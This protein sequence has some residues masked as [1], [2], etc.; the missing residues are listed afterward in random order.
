M[1]IT[2]LK[3]GS[4]LLIILAALI[5]GLIPI[6]MK[7]SQSN[8]KWLVLGNAMAGGIFLGAGL[9]H[10][11]PESAEHFEAFGTHFPFAFVLA[12]IGF[13]LILLLEKVFLAGEHDVGASSAKQNHFSPFL[14]TLILS[15]H[16]IMYCL[17]R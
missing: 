14:L 11:L 9:L 8:E 17:E 4:I 2:F 1:E 12:G 7:V 10:M 13:L 16:S 15:L 6:R 5:G 3:I